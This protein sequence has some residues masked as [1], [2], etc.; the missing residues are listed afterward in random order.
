MLSE[1]RRSFDS[2]LGPLSLGISVVL[3]AIYLPGLFFSLRTH[4]DLFN[5][6][7]TAD[8]DVY[9]LM[10]LVFYYAESSAARCAPAGTPFEKRRTPSVIS[11]SVNG[12]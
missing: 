6:G 1:S 10:G 12:A 3:I 4:E 8:R 11:L 5:P 9:A 2:Q 7:Q